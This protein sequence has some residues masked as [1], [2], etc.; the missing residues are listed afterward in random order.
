M[1]NYNFQNETIVDYLPNKVDLSQQIL[2]SSDI[3]ERR[4]IEINPPNSNV[5][6]ISSTSASNV[7]QFKIQSETEFIDLQNWNLSFQ[8]TNVVIPAP[9]GSTVNVVQ[10]DGRYACI[11]RVSCVC[12]GQEVATINNNFAKHRNA[13]YMNEAFVQNYLSDG[14]L[15]NPGNAKLKSVLTD[16]RIPTSATF[17]GD[18]VNN[19]PANMITGATAPGANNIDVNGVKT[20][21]R[22][23]NNAGFGAF[24]TDLADCGTQQVTI[25]MSELV[26]LFEIDRY[27]PL[28]L[29][30]GGFTINIYWSSP[31]Q[32][33]FTDAGVFTPYAAAPAAG[34]VA[35]SAS[36]VP[37]PITS[38][39]IKNIKMVCDLITPSETLINSYKM[40]ANSDEGFNLIYQDFQVNSS[41][42]VTY[43]GN[44]NIQY[45]VNLSSSSLT[46]VLIYFQ[47]NTVANAS[48]GWS[49]SHFPYLGVKNHSI[50]LNNKYYPSVA[51]N[52]PQEMALYSARGKAVLGNQLSNFVCFNPYVYG[53]AETS[54]TQIIPGSS[55]TAGATSD[56]AT[57]A[58]AFLIYHGLEKVFGE[59][60]SVIKNGLDLKNGT[61]Q[62]TIKYDE[63]RSRVGSSSLIGA[64]PNNQYTSYALCTFQRLFSIRN[65][66]LEIIG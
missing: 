52:T 27:F 36:F 38:Y 51:L 13:K 37:T 18:L 22:T 43:N 28:F 4:T 8:V 24:T 44:G 1:D 12:A 15:L 66:Q 50:Q 41:P 14:M 30:N 47:S 34:G 59:G 23:A 6:G 57:S 65:G 39:E 29:L 56:Y 40:A 3:K 55:T 25:P 45:Q 17:Y 21:S 26:S 11:E 16:S 2:L 33:F 61:S 31:T 48:N 62:I 64:C 5:I 20:A 46:S 63:D 7:S 10:L 60:N 42:T 9:A 35:T 49:N 54:V 58:T 53:W 19:N 32:A